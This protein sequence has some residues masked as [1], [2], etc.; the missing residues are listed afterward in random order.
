MEALG[1]HCVASG[2][3]DAATAEARFDIV[4]LCRLTGPGYEYRTVGSVRPSSG[5]KA[6][7]NVVESRAGR[8]S[9][10][11]RPIVTMKRTSQILMGWASASCIGKALLV[12]MYSTVFTGRSAAA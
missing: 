11:R 7:R 8:K 2:G 12:S 4:V 5:L 6:A 3:A 9:G 10:V 1:S